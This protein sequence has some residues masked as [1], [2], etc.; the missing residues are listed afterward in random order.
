MLLGIDHE[1]ILGQLEQEVVDLPLAQIQREGRTIY[2]SC[3]MSPT[4]GEPVL[5]DLG[6]ARIC[7]G[8]QKGLVMPAIYRAPEVMLGMEWDETVDL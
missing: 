1:A 8:K 2:Q 6:E 3:S 4:G 7:T 5:A